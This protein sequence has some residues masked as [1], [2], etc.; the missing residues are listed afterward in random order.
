MELKSYDKAWLPAFK[1]ALLI[2]FGI[3]SI[4]W[5]FNTIKTLAVLFVALIGMMAFLLIGIGYYVQKI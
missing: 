1:G 5:M 2:L 4:L 3:F